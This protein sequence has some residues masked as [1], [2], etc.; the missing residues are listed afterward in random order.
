MTL[1]SFLGDKKC[2]EISSGGVQ[3]ST[4]LWIYE[5]TCCIFQKSE[6]HGM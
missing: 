1:V 2:S 3:Y 6:F 5:K 4:T